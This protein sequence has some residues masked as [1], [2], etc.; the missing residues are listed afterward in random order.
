MWEILGR[1][2]DRTWRVHGN[3]THTGRRRT[4]KEDAQ[5]KRMHNRRGRITEGDAPQKRTHNGRGHITEGDAP[6]MRTHHGG[7]RTTEGGCTTDGDT[8]RKG[9]HN[10]GADWPY[11][12]NPPPTACTCST[13]KPKA[14]WKEKKTGVGTELTLEEKGEK[15]GIQ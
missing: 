15:Q 13:L 11:I 9:T 2:C 3:G 10:R 8:Q 7:G 4:T 6:Q 12:C 1:V 5:Q 14:T